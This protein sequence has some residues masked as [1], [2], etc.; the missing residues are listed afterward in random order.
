MKKILFISLV[1]LI[2]N[3]F[4]KVSAYEEA[5]F[6]SGSSA[7]DV[8]ELYDYM[9][10]LGYLG[11]CIQRYGD[12]K[13]GYYNCICACNDR[14]AIS[15]LK[16]CENILSKHPEWGNR[17]VNAKFGNS[18]RVINPVAFR[19]IINAVKPCLNK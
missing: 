11:N 9:S 16:K 17:A 18:T 7:S 4:I 3:F 19:T 6:V 8:I 1:L 2:F 5:Y 12:V 13:T 15:V 10:A 14:N